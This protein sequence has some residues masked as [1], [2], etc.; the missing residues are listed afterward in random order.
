[1]NFAECRQLKEVDMPE[2]MTFISS[3]VFQNC[4][5]LK[6]IIC[7]AV[8]P[9]ESDYYMFY[10]SFLNYAECTLYIPIGT[11]DA[12]KASP[13]FKDFLNICETDFHTGIYSTEIDTKQNRVYGLDGKVLQQARK[14]LYILRQNDGKRVKIIR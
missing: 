4:V 9:P 6:R 12:Y 10:Y 14:G 5:G 1:M 8:V 11:T 2:T 7:R 13:N 3:N